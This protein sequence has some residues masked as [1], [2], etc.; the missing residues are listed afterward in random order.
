MFEKNVKTAFGVT[1]ITSQLMDISVLKWMNIYYGKPE[2]V[3]PDNRIKTI[4]FAKAVC[5]E[6]ARLTNLA[7]AIE[8][9]GG[10][11]AEFLKKHI[12]KAIMPHLREWVEYGCA[13]GTVII[14]PN[15][16]GADLVTP[17]RFW[18]IDMDGNR[19]ISG[20]V[21]QDSY[22]SEKEYYTKWSITDI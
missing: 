9:D 22:Q 19:N 13:A 17:D 7:V 10:A 5:S 4:N 8:L 18:V 6:T 2:W 12:D 20:I 14:K 15:G 1:P 3:D 16:E 11:R 21:F